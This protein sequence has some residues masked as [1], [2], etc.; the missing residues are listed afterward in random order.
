[1]TN[2]LHHTARFYRPHLLAALV[3]N[4]NP[5]IVTLHLR[6]RLQKYDVREEDVLLRFEDGEEFKADLVVG[7]D[8]IKSV[9][10]HPFQALWYHIL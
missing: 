9:S 7:S 6:K 8:G 4:T 1:M 3:E 2:P 5:E 10:K